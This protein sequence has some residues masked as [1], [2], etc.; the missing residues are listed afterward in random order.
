VYKK[1]EEA[2][3]AV[4]KMSAIMRY[5]LNDAK[6]DRIL[7]EKEIE[8][9]KSYIELEKLRIKHKDFVEM[10]VTGNPAGRSIAPMLLIPFIENSFKHGAKNVPCPGIIIDLVIEPGRIIFEV[11]NYMRKSTSGDQ[12]KIGGIGLENIRRR[13]GLHYPGKHELTIWHEN[14]LYKIKLVLWS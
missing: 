5:V 8:Y 6:N 2:P 14:E 4:M 7:I 9:L 10:N 11:S 13:L 1:S 3:A 12:D